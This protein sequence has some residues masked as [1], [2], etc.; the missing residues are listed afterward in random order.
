MRTPHDNVRD[1]WLLLARLPPYEVEE[2]FRGGVSVLM[3]L[4]IGFA[5]GTRQRG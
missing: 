4:V 2:C 5:P 1:L 3:G